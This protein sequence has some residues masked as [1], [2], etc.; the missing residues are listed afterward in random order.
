VAMTP[1]DRVQLPAALEALTPGSGCGR[2]RSAA[3]AG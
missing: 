2:G 1:N 3:T